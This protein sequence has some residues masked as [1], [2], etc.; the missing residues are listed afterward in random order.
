MNGC[1]AG[2]VGMLSGAG[3]MFGLGEGLRPLR[4]TGIE[5]LDDDGRRARQLQQEAKA[6]RVGQTRTESFSLYVLI[7]HKRKQTLCHVTVTHSAL[8]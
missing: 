6:G 5:G 3:G 2:T 1:E 7:R 8:S 4:K